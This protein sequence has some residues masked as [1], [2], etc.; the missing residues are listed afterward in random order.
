MQFWVNMKLVGHSYTEQEA[1]MAGDED[2]MWGWKQHNGE[3][4]LM[5]ILAY[6]LGIS[7]FSA[8]KD[9][10]HLFSLV[11]VLGSLL[12]NGRLK[13]LNCNIL[14]SRAC[15]PTQYPRLSEFLASR[16]RA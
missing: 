12:L 10:K 4:L 11:S 7:F 8:E 1:K 5:D 15:A 2:P 6:C 9:S 3:C 16:M 13:L 14:E